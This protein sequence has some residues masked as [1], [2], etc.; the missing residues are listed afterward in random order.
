MTRRLW[1]ERTSDGRGNVAFW[2]VDAPP[3]TGFVGWN[4]YRSPEPCSDLT[5][6]SLTLLTSSPIGV[7]FLV[8]PVEAPTGVFGLPS[9]LVTQVDSGGEHT[10]D[11]PVQVGDTSDPKRQGRRFP[12]IS[13]PRVFAEFRRRKQLLLDLNGERVTVLVRR[14]GGRRC[15]DCF[16]GQFESPAKADC[17]TCWGTGW[18]RGYEALTDVPMRISSIEEALK[19]QPPGLVFASNPKGWSV[20]FPL[21]RQGDVVVRPMAGKRYGVQK[22]DLTVHQGI[23]TGQDFDLVDFEPSDPIYGFPA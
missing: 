4:V 7:A 3:P 18:D 10:I 6:S 14:L 5:S 19:L 1:V 13:M 17:R 2:T 16:S 11:R 20:G 12:I 21:L 8:D 23:L 9:Y 22:V 15:P